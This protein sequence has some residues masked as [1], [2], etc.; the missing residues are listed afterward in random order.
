MKSVPILLLASLMLAGCATSTIQ[1][2]QQERS[3]AYAALSPDFRNLVDQGQIKIGMSTDAV[4]IAWGRPAE[5]L[6]GETAQ[7]QTV[8]WL[9]HGTELEEY[10][11]WSYRPF[12]HRSYVF[13]EPSLQHDYYPRDYVSAEVIFQNGAV[14]EWRSLPRPR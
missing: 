11:Y 2:R 5:I 3:A 1:T 9:Y 14:K 13:A 4:Y 8:T 6:A 10:R 7:G 12:Y